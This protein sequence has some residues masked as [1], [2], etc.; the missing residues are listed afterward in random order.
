MR[1]HLNDKGHREQHQ[2]QFDQRTHVQP[3]SDA[4]VNSLASVEAIYC[5]RRTASGNFMVVAVTK[6]P[7][8]FR[9][10]PA[11]AEESP[12]PAGQTGRSAR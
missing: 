2:A 9:R 3:G 11:Q 7:P 5:R 12:R 1:D 10:S 4:S 6:A 8:S